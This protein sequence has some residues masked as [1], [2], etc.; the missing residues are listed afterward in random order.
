[1]GKTTLLVC[2]NFR[3]EFKEAIKNINDDVEIVT[4]PSF[5]TLEKNGIKYE[6]KKKL[7]EHGNLIV[8]C[9]TFCDI[10]NK[11]PKKFQSK[12]KFYKFENCFYMFGKSKV[13]KYIEEG[14]YLITPG[15]LVNWKENISA[16]GFNK[17]TAR[18]FFK[19]NLKKLVL[20]NTN[21]EN[22]IERKLAEL[23]TFLDLPYFI[24]EIDLDYLELL[25]SKALGEIEKE[26]KIK[27]L[28]MEKSNYIAAFSILSSISKVEKEEEVVKVIIEQI[29]MLFSPKKIEYIPYSGHDIL[30]GR[31][32]EIDTNELEVTLK[33]KFWNET[34]GFLKIGQFMFPQYFEPYVDFLIYVKDV[35]GLAISNVRRFEK[36]MDVAISDT[37]T[38]IFNRKYFELKLSEELN[39]SSREGKIFSL[40][41]FDLD[42]FKEVNDK[43]GHEFGDEILV[44]LVE[45]VRKRLRKTDFFFRW[46]GDEFIILL[47]NTDL[48]SAE[49]LAKELKKVLNNIEAN[50]IKI[51]ASFGV[52][53]YIGNEMNQEK[54]FKK[55]DEALYMAKKL[56][57]NTVF[58]N[59]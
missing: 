11:I 53:S 55:L 51:S 40:I 59:K 42:N 12:V 5:C 26:Q 49:I 57:K 20:L 35:F 22:G 27:Q 39:R 41:M 36:I 56:G 48:N 32:Y 46:G 6:V 1:M 52:I 44:K 43:Y 23:A 34:F 17:E 16:Y 10:I 15:W 31:E 38:G 3:K 29:K 33:I 13:K 30:N 14:A 7:L 47:P 2:E 25:I 21:V 18:R 58:V 24:E 4:F 8:F 28:V 37:L 19:E 45:A 9:C 54:L 50:G